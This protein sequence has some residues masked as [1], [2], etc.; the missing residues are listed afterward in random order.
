MLQGQFTPAAGIALGLGRDTDHRRPGRQ[1]GKQVEHRQVELQ[2]REREDSVVAVQLQA[3]L[4]VFQGVGGGQMAD[5]HALG[6]TRGAGGIEDIGQVADGSRP[7][8][9]Q[10]GAGGGQLREHQAGTRRIADFLATRRRLIDADGQVRGAARQ[11]AQH[12]DHLLGPLGQLQR[13][14]VAAP[15]ALAFQVGRHLQ[16]TF[17]EF[18]VVDDGTIAVQ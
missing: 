2:R 7:R 16:S 10:R 6:L 11:D 17:G 18:A 8:G 15:D 4:Q 9:I 14:H 3:P 13:H 12:R 1:R 5:F